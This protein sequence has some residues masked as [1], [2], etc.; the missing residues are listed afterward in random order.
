M[1]TH[2]DEDNIYNRISSQITNHPNL[3][4]KKM[5]WGRIFW[6]LNANGRNYLNKFKDSFDP[7]N[8]KFLFE[9]DK[10]EVF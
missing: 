9:P 4:S 1:C 5:V 8:D 6:K 10:I 7:I 2:F 3:F